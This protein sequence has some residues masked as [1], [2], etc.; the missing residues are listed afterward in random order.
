MLYALTKKWSILRPHKSDFLLTTKFF[1]PS[2]IRMNERGVPSHK[3]KY[4]S[5][6]KLCDNALRK[7]YELWK[8]NSKCVKYGTKSKDFKIFCS[9]CVK[10]GTNL[11]HLEFFFSKCVKSVHLHFVWCSLLTHFEKKCTK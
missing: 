2:W 5:Y 11:T 9:K 8:K 3:E 4:S 7:N 6:L 10:F 1:I